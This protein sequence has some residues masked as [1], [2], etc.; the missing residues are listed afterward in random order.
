[1]TDS[2]PIPVSEVQADFE[3]REA[4]SQKFRRSED[5]GHSPEP[6]YL[7]GRPLTTKAVDS[8]FWVEIGDG[9]STVLP[10]GHGLGDDETLGCFP[11]GSECARKVERPFKFKQSTP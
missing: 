6:C 11:V 1:M 2:N 7:C 10:N 9:G 8:G 3:T 5:A 4:N